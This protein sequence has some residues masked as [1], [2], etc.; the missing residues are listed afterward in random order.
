MRSFGWYIAVVVSAYA[1]SASWSLGMA[2]QQLSVTQQYATQ[3]STELDAAQ[4]QVRAL[5]WQNVCAAEAATCS[6]Q[7]APW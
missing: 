7:A 6:D 5:E 3:L 4:N 1:I 2:S